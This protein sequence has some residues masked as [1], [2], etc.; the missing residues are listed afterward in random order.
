M[1]CHKNNTDILRLIRS[2]NVGPKTYQD[3]IKLYGSAKAALE[4]VE[5]LSLTGGRKIPIKLCSLDQAEKELEAAS[6]I[7]ANILSHHDL[8]YPILLKETDDFPP[9]ITVLG[10]ITLLNKPQLAIVGARNA[11]SNGCLFAYHMAKDLAKEGIIT[12]SGLARGID[13]ASHKGAL[14][15]GTS[16]A[17]IAG[18]I[19]NIYPPEN[20]EL[21]NLIANKGA[22]I[23]ELP[24]ESIPKSIHF[25]Q[26]NRIISGLSFGT[27]VVEATLKSGSLITARI[28]L[29]QNREV[30]SVPGFPMDPRCKGTNYLLK[31]GAI[32]VENI[33]DILDNIQFKIKEPTNKLNDS[34]QND[35]THDHDNNYSESEFNEART[36]ILSSLSCSPTDIDEICFQYKIPSKIVITIIV[37]LELAGKIE[38]LPGNK[39]ALIYQNH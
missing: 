15:T 24:Y 34:K 21:R 26:R 39:I 20:K 19:D 28:A 6:K 35:Y 29:A 22:V 8:D 32:L 36:T 25:P 11:S 14:T 1:N 13:T 17:V 30:F 3:L 38:R 31:Q 16:I 12:T 10:D 18:G 5:K 33:N 27:L 4:Q 37:E 23:A 9:I 2:E 7:G